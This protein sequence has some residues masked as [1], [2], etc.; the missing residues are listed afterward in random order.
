MPGESAS[1][2]EPR[3]W[4]ISA[5][6][7]QGFLAR[8]RE[9]WQYRRILGFFSKKSVQSLYAK[10]RLGV[11][12]L[13]IRALVPLGVASFVFGS[14]MNVPSAGVPYFLFFLIGQIPW[15]C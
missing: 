4:V 14:V 7:D 2:A 1:S 13:F 6:E 12:W 10:S 8:A 11:I 15:N 3:A 5:G 9:V